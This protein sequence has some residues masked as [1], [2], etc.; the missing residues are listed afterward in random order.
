M[1]ALPPAIRTELTR[2]TQLNAKR[3]A[4][5][6][7]RQ[8]PELSGELRISI[9]YYAAQGFQGTVWRVRAGVNG[10]EGFYARFVEFGTQHMQAEP[11]FFVTYRAMRSSFRSRSSRAIRRGIQKAI[12]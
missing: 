3:F 2:A 9:R 7:E 10:G 4:E 5:A 11:F 8:A 1:R 6:A 12:K